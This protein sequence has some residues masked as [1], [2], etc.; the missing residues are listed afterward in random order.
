[1]GVVFIGILI[2]INCIRNRHVEKIETPTYSPAELCKA[3]LPPGTIVRIYFR[4]PLTPTADPLIWEYRPG[5]PVELIPPTMRVFFAHP[6][7]TPPEYIT[8]RIDGWQ[9]DLLQR[10]NKKTAALVL[11]AE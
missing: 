3:N 8:A 4:L 7:H 10:H 6:V 11:T 2:A 1:M 9:E 5:H